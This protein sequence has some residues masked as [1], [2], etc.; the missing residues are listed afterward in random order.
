MN[1]H[2]AIC[3][4]ISSLA[5]QILSK[6]DESTGIP[7][8]NIIRDE[9][10]AK[11]NMYKIKIHA[12]KLLKK[13]EVCNPNLRTDNAKIITRDFVY[14]FQQKEALQWLY[15]VNCFNEFYMLYTNFLYYIDVLQYATDQNL[16]DFSDRR[17]SEGLRPDG[18]YRPVAAYRDIWPRYEL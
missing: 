11:S 6:T 5:K 10:G 15:S 7:V 16:L 14:L 9:S 1:N 12:Y 13:C 4:N 17:P 2:E 18:R 3:T 8:V